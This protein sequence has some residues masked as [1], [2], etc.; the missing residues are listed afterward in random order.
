MET[1]WM[2]FSM[3]TSGP[4]LQDVDVFISNDNEGAGQAAA[5]GYFSNPFIGSAL[6]EFWLLCSDYAWNVWIHVVAR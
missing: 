5:K 6:A 2:P 3:A 1:F 4:D